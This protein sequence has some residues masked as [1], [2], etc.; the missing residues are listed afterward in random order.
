MSD[1]KGLVTAEEIGDLCRRHGFGCYPLNEEIAA[2]VAQRWIER[3]QVKP[4]LAEKIERLLR[5]TC[6]GLVP[7]ELDGG[8]SGAWWRMQAEKIAALAREELNG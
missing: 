4:G 7:H 8:P 3:T 5:R 6:G 2:L 1:E